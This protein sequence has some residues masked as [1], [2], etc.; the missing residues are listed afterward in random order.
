MAES[1]RRIGRLTLPRVQQVLW[2]RISGAVGVGTARTMI[3]EAL[4]RGRRASLPE[5]PDELV[6][7]VKTHL[8][9]ALL[10]ALGPRALSVL[11]DELAD[12]PPPSSRER[13]SPSRGVAGVR[14]AVVLVDRDPQRLRSMERALRAAG[15]AVLPL[16]S[17]EELVLLD[18]RVDVV[19]GEVEGVDVGAMMHALTAF[20]PTP[21]FVAR[22]V[23]RRF[24]AVRILHDARLPRWDVLANEATD[25]ELVKC[26]ETL[27]ATRP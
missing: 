18:A 14:A 22:I 19:I 17:Y 16:S 10:D 4:Q 8:M 26:V 6:A 9:S 24:D 5:D 7:F 20:Q 11:L 15:F 3:A 23:H 1:K 27:G 25:E 2:D 21:A 12:E 13:P